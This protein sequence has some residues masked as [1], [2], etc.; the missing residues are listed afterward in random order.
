MGS[1]FRLQPLLPAPCPHPA[2]MPRLGSALVHRPYS[3]LLVRLGCPSVVPSRTKPSP[4]VC[5]FRL[6]SQSAAPAVPVEAPVPVEVPVQPCLH[7]LHLRPHLC[8]PWL[9]VLEL[10]FS[11]PAIRL[12]SLLQPYSQLWLHPPSLDDLSQQSDLRNG[13]LLCRSKLMPYMITILGIWY[14]ALRAPTLFV[15]N[16]SFAPNIMQ[17]V[18]LSV[19]RL[20][21]LLMDSLRF[22]A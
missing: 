6:P 5:L 18:L 3:P 11:S 13:L 20:V 15:R 16:G 17:M 9:L 21:W 2:P 7:R 1:S 8:T 12:I 10:E 19:T 4:S 14:L 22:L